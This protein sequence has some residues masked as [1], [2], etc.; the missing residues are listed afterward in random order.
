MTTAYSY[1]INHQTNDLWPRMKNKT[2]FP[3]D[4]ASQF[5]IDQ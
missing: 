1:F 2:S 3:T 5:N 4:T